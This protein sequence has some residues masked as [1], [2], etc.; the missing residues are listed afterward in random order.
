MELCL[1]SAVRTARRRRRL[2]GSVSAALEGLTKSVAVFAHPRPDAGRDVYPRRS[3]QTL[4]TRT[5]NRKYVTTLKVQRLRR[6][7]SCPY[8]EG[9]PTI[10]GAN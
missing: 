5:D 2:Y 6:N 1:T 7:R 10:P 8:G 9:P 3:G 4:I